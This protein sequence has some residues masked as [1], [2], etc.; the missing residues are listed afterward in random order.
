MA[1]PTWKHG[2]HGAG[3]VA[4]RAWWRHCPAPVL[5]HLTLGGHASIV[6]EKVAQHHHTP[7]DGILRLAEHTNSVVFRRALRHP[8]ISPQLLRQ[9]WEAQMAEG[10]STSVLHSLAENPQCPADLLHLAATS[11]DT[12]LQLVAAKHPNTNLQDLVMLATNSRLYI[13]AAASK[14]LPQQYQMLVEIAR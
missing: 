2:T 6:L 10:A 14:Q 7:L 1:P 5:L 3:N 9:E 12:N 8:V 11:I 4:H 13:A